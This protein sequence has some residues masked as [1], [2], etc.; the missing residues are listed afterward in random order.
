MIAIHVENVKKFMSDLFTGNLFDNFHVRHC[1]VV[2]FLRLELEGER[3]REWYDTGEYP[4]DRQNQIA[5][6]ECKPIVFQWIK[7]KKTPVK[8]KLDFCHYLENG[9]IGSLRIEYT[10]ESLTA[11]T[12]YMQKDFSMDRE[13]QQEWDYYCQNVLEKNFC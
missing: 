4:E 8:M 3:C 2:T 9:D 11:Y 10:R 6:S 5:W 7:G 1:E 13:G 12:G